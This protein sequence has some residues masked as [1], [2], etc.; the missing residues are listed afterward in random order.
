MRRIKKRMEPP[1]LSQWRA[2][3]QGDP[4]GAGI[5]YGYDVLRQ[6]P[7]VV[8]ALMESLLAE[9]GSLCAYTGKRIDAHSAHVEHLFPQ[10]HGERG[11]DVEYT[12]LVA[13]WPQPNGPHGEYGAHPK[14]D[15]PNAEEQHFFVSPLSAECEARFRF[16]NRGEIAPCADGDLAAETT[17]QRLKLK[18][19][20]LTALRKSEIDG[21]L[22]KERKLDLKKAR[23]RLTNLEATERDLDAG[24]NVS[25]E[26]YCFVL[27]QVLVKFIRTVERLRKAK[28]G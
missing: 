2:S 5:N 17:I 18:H 25:L 19:K 13:C 8:Q 21:V 16:N 15:W 20:T 10:A 23:K 22:G 4:Q 1:Q 7:E 27:K 12:N 6:S 26:P 28:K 3:N 9:Q 24:A 11:Q 14:A